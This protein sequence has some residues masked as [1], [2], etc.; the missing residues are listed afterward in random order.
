MTA[1]GF[2]ARTVSAVAVTF[3]R[4][5]TSSCSISCSR[6]RTMSPNSA[7]LVTRTAQ[8]ICPPRRSSF[9]SSVTLW[10]RRAAMMAAFRPAG[11]PPITVTRFGVAARCRVPMP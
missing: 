5:S 11:P 7:R 9:S 10:P 6:L 4:T 8:T 2:A 3:V 1:S